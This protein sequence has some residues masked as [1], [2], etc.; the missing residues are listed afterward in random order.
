MKKLFLKSDYNQPEIIID[1]ELGLVSFSGRAHPENIEPMLN[2]LKEWL[3][4]YRTSPA[5]ITTVIIKLDYF[6]TTASKVFIYFLTKLS[7]IENTTINVE[8]YYFDVDTLE[9]IK[10]LESLLKI[11]FNCINAE[12]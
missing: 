5:T 9:I 4:D 10:D 1:S 11:R 6:N 3:N 2:P 8:W 12:K 7:E